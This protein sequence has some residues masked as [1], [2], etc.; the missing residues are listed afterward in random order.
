MK[1]FQ[2]AKLINH[3]LS[4]LEGLCNRLPPLKNFNLRNKVAAEV[5]VIRLIIKNPDKFTQYWKNNLP[6]EH[7]NNIG[8]FSWAK[9]NNMNS[10]QRRRWFVESVNRMTSA[11]S[12]VLLMP[13]GE[14]VEEDFKDIRDIY[15]SNNHRFFERTVLE[16]LFNHILE[17][18][19]NSEIPE[20]RGKDINSVDSI[21]TTVEQTMK[22]DSRKIFKGLLRI[23][24]YKIGY[25]VFSDYK[26]DSIEEFSKENAVTDSEDSEADDELQIEAEIEAQYNLLE[27]MMVELDEYLDTESEA[28]VVDFLKH[29]YKTDVLADIHKIKHTI[30]DEIIKKNWQPDENWQRFFVN[31]VNGFYRM[32]ETLE[33]KPFPDYD[34][35]SVPHP[36]PGELEKKIRT[37]FDEH[38]L[39]GTDCVEVK[40]SKPG[41][42]Y[43]N[44]LFAPPEL[45]CSKSKKT[46]S[47]S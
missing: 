22:R 27:D 24:D 12:K 29:L 39:P 6:P 7:I 25:S 30:I 4:D 21:L 19:D 17:M 31:L 16:Q 2:N 35:L 42:F 10:R 9:A 32:L 13:S 45:Q 41:F 8:F 23:L 34:S 33:V 1:A 36:W 43:K 38:H 37:R 40:I 46:V 28:I 15:R 18:T 3:I 14:V 44:I 47:D 26:Q 5:E 11:L 20:M